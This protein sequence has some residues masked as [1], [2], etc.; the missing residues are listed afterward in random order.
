VNVDY[1]PGGKQAFPTGEAH[2][3]RLSAGWEVVSLD[4]LPAGAQAAAPPPPPLPEPAED[5]DGRWELTSL[6]PAGGDGG[7]E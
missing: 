3:L 4:E 5:D 7:N 6:D 2:V 1:A